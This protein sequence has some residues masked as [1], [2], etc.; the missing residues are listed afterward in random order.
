MASYILWEGFNYNSRGGYVSQRTTLFTTQGHTADLCFHYLPSALL[1]RHVC[2]PELDHR[3]RQNASGDNGHLLGDL[4]LEALDIL[5]IFM[6]HDW[7]ELL[8]LGSTIHWL[9]ASSL[10]HLRGLLLV[11]LDIQSNNG[12]RDRVGMSI[13]ESSRTHTFVPTKKDKKKNDTF[14]V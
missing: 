3:S 7:E 9:E 12:N 10:Y 11:Q 14:F 4:E 13:S 2:S 6:I 8:D 1:W 5:V